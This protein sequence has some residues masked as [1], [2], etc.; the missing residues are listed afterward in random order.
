MAFLRSFTILPGRKSVPV[1]TF[2]N[3]NYAFKPKFFL[4]AKGAAS[5]RQ[6]DKHRLSMLENLRPISL[7]NTDYKILAKP[8]PKR[9]EKVVPKTVNSDIKPVISKV[10]SL[11]RMLGQLKTL[12]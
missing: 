1:I 2:R 5:W 9:L 6:E 11:A 12:C 7:L 3:V 8:I 4:L 10:V